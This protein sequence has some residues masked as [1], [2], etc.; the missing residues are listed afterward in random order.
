MSILSLLLTA[1][2]LFSARGS[3]DPSAWSPDFA[4]LGANGEVRALAVHD[5]ELVAAGSFTYVGTAPALNIARYDGMSW[6][7]M[8]ASPA[9]AIGVLRSAGT[10]LY[11]GIT[12]V[13][14][15]GTTQAVY[16]WDGVNWTALPDMPQ[17]VSSVHALVPYQ[18]NLLA[19]VSTT[20][21]GLQTYLWDGIAWSSFGVGVGGD[22]AVDGTTVY[23]LSPGIYN[24]LAKWDGVAWSAVQADLTLW[25]EGTSCSNPWPDSNGAL[26]AL[27]LLDGRVY[28]G[29]RFDWLIS[30]DW[31]TGEFLTSSHDLASW[32]ITGWE[33]ESGLP[34]ST[35]NGFSRIDH[36]VDA[37]D[38]FDEALWVSSSNHRIYSFT[39]S[40]AT[41]VTGQF[42]RT[43]RATARFSGQL[44]AAG[45]FALVNG[46]HVG[47]IAYLDG[48][49]W[50]PL[51]SG[52][53]HVPPGQIVALGHADTVPVVGV[54]GKLLS[55]DG[56]QWAT[57]KTFT[58]VDEVYGQVLE[59]GAATALLDTD[60]GLYVAALD[61]IET[62]VAVY[63]FSNAPTNWSSITL[64]AFETFIFE[65]G[66][67]RVH[68]FY[69]HQNELYAG[70]NFYGSQAAALF[71]IARW[72]GSAWQP[73]DGGLWSEEW[74]PFDSCM[75]LTEFNGQL[76]A[77]GWFDMAS[78]TE[79][80]SIA[81]WNGT[82]WSGFDGGMTGMPG[83][84]NCTTAQV[85]ALASYGGELIAGGEFLYAGG[86][87][88]AYLARW[89][90][91]AWQAFGTPN[92][93]VNRL[94]VIQDKLLVAGAFSEIGGQPIPR[95]A[96]WDG[97]SW[98][99]LAG[100][101]DG[102]AAHVTF[103]GAALLV[104]G[105]FDMAGSVQSDGI[106]A[107]EDASVFLLPTGV[108]TPPLG[109]ARL[110]VIPNPMVGRAQVRVS[111]PA[112]ATP[113]SLAVYDLRGRRVRTLV[114]A[115][116]GKAGTLLW[117]GRDDDGERLA[118]GT[119]MVRLQTAGQVLHEK[120]V[121]LR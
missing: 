25:T 118:V 107:W 110:S 92:G 78:G 34:G 2:P 45:S 14:S 88:N 44:I 20:S 24:G 35:C 26:S 75:A 53:S 37:I 33:N 11:A 115:D 65:A 57:R 3:G 100:G 62:Q 16:V 32:S 114:P 112:S 15:P 18:G 66:A 82:S 80:N 105:N 76:V 102:P 85:S 89:N 47:N 51:G 52:P 58:V 42:D 108:P 9:T 41:T 72:D 56:T 117:D 113:Y 91:S 36:G 106:A 28:V 6:S 10:L 13:S 22:L 39:T 121:V 81:T 55:F 86:E 43:I 68:V 111:L 46:V 12:G 59:A 27:E 29:G 4:L 97:T 49:T 70:G 23:A 94:L 48:S 96:L 98:S 73:L 83:C 17:S 90:G 64:P 40:G 54:P 19:G 99:D 87:P 5:D 38:A 120:V 116:G 60:A 84:I 101:L 74:P 30:G 71:N 63:R 69:E 77:G 119:Y 103:T 67:R 7:G 95:L 50:R 8:P 104:A 93:A 79:V 109:G 61:G 31:L 1:S 21:S